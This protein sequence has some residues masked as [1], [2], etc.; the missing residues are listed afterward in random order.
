[1]VWI[2]I[3]IVYQAPPNAV[4]WNGPWSFGMTHVADAQYASEAECRSEAVQFIGRM[5]QGMLAPM[6]YRCIEVPA[7][8]PKGAER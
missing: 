8:L 6:R 5:H 4:D 1:M 2:A 3:F 7:S